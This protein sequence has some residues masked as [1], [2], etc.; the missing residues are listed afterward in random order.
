MSPDNLFNYA[1]K[2]CKDAEAAGLGSKYPTF[3][4]VARRFKVTHDQIEQACED[5]Q[6][7]GYMRP[8][9][10]FRSNSG[11]ATFKTRGE[12]LVEAYR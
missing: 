6:G 9:V 2:F 7:E 11:Y 4:Q 8:A 5:W 10:G 12:H 1:V 3:R